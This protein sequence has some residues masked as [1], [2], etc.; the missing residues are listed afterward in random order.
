MGVLKMVGQDFFALAHYQ[1]NII[2]FIF[3]FLMFNRGI[4]YGCSENGPHDPSACQDRKSAWHPDQCLQ[5]Q[6][7]PP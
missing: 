4:V 7:G 5:I 6:L 2:T 1:I 3:T